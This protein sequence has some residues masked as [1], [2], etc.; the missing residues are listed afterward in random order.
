MARR[1]NQA[2]AAALLLI[3]ALYAGAATAHGKESLE[4]DS[5]VR[6]I[7]ENM[8]HFSA[9]QPQHDPSAQYCSEIPKGGET[10]LVVDL[11]DEALRGMPIGMRV[12]R[13]TSETED[14]TVSYLRPSYHPDG[15]IKGETS[16]DQGLYTVIITAEGLPP[17]RYQYSL[18][19]QMINYANIFRTAVGPLIGLLLLTLLGY[20]LMK[21]KRMERWRAS[22]RQ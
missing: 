15:V 3:T 21:S 13:G 22:R 12:V 4:E 9:Y 11:V 16:L 6:R 7:G 8:V 20:K 1:R 2:S 19:V 17:L 14:E 5:C 18:R 10:Y